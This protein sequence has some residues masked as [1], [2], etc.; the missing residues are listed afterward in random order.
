MNM[1]SEGRKPAHLQDQAL[2]SNYCLKHKALFYLILSKL[3]FQSLW[4]VF[5]DKMYL[6]ITNYDEDS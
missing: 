1:S 6:I 5:L 4:Q 3:Y 2:E